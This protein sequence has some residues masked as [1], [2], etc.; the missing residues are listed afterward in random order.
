M[1]ATEPRRALAAPR[2]DATSGSARCS[3]STTSIST[4]V[5]ARWWRCSATTAPASRRSSSASAGRTGSTRATI[6][7]DGAAG[8]TSTRP[9]TRARAGIETVYQDLALFDNLYPGGN[10]YAGRELGGRAG[11]R[12]GCASCGR[13]ADARRDRAPCSSGCRSASPTPTPSVGLMSG[14]QRQAIAVARAAAFASRVVILD[15]PTA[16]LGVRESRQVLDLIPRLREEGAAV[17]V[18]S[19]AH[20]PRHRDRRPGRG[21]APRPRGRRGG[22]SAETQQQIVALIVGGGRDGGARGPPRDAA[23]RPDAGHDR[24]RGRNTVSIR[25]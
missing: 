4:C 6:E 3:R 25:S 24:L 15:E 18:I 1:I 8:A 14:G 21:D 17:I 22:P 13:R 23:R 9:P 16:A 10:F 2:R 20:G 11:C 7:I 19:H 5:A 12:A